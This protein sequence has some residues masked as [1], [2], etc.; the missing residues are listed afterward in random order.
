MK[1]RG[2]II[3]LECNS[4]VILPTVGKKPSPAWETMFQNWTKDLFY[5]LWWHLWMYRPT[6]PQSPSWFIIRLR[7]DYLNQSGTLNTKNFSSVNLSSMLIHVGTLV[8]HLNGKDYLMPLWDDAINLTNL[9]T[10]RQLQNPKINSVCSSNTSALLIAERNLRTENFISVLI[11]VW[12]E[13]VEALANPDQN[14]C[15]R[16]QITFLQQ[17][18]EIG[19]RSLYQS[20]ARRGFLSHSR[21][22]RC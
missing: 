9:G 13:D 11:R 7:R 6:D 18:N 4:L 8:A 16:S 10:I 3:N 5:N 20:N 19:G 12:P 14:I 2:I 1:S 21:S 17:R 22:V 15:V